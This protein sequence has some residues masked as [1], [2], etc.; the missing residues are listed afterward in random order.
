M[1]ALDASFDITI[2]R[3][4][5]T[6]KGKLEVWTM[7]ELFSFFE[8]PVKTN[9]TIKAYEL[10]SADERAD[11]KD[12]GGYV[13]GDFQNNTRK[14]SNL[15]GRSAVALDMDFAP[16]D[17]ARLLE[18]KLKW[19]Y[20]AHTTHSH[21]IERPRVRVI[22]FLSCPV[23]PKQYEKLALM[24]MEVIGIKYFDKTTTEPARLM[25]WPSVSADG[26]YSCMKDFNLPLYTPSE[27]LDA[28][29]TP[30]DYNHNLG[31]EILSK[32]AEDPTKKAGIIGAFCRLYP[33]EKAIDEL[34]S[35]YYED[36]TIANRYTY[37]LSSTSN[38]AVV[39]D[40]KWLYSHHETDPCNGRLVNSWDLV[41][42]HKFGAL[43]VDFVGEDMKSPSQSAML[44]FAERLPG[45]KG[46]MIK[47]KVEGFGAVDGGEPFAPGDWLDRLKTKK[48]KVLPSFQNVLLI[49]EN[50]DNLSGVVSFNTFSC[51]KV[52]TKSF[53][54][55]PLTDTENG[56]PWG[57]GLDLLIRHYIESRYGVE[58]A[59]QRVC[60]ALDTVAQQNRFN[61][62]T[63]WLSGLEWDGVARVNNL[64]CSYLGAEDS[65]LNKAL[66]RK[67]LCGAVARAYNPGCQFDY[68]PILCGAQ[69]IG[70]SRFIEAL[71]R[72]YSSDNL[73]H[74][75]GN[76][77]VE[78]VLGKWILE[79]PELQAF[80]KSQIEQIKA[81]ITRST[82]RTRLAYARSVQSYP[83]QCVLIGTT[84]SAEFLLDE[85]GNRRFWPI[86]CNAEKVDVEK[87]KK[88]VGQIW[89]EAVIMYNKGEQL[90]LEEEL[91]PDV[92]RAQKSKMVSDPW[93]GEIEAWLSK[94][95]PS[96]YYEI[97][98]GQV[99]P[100]SESIERAEVCVTDVWQNCLGQDIGRLTK[101]DS[102]RL[103][104]VLSALQGWSKGSITK[105]LG[106]RFGVQ[107]VWVRSC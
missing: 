78:A 52:Q 2:F 4:K 83:R 60:E 70:K 89:A 35:D 75:D 25:F 80:N 34:V 76:Q 21:T 72:G 105:R 28:S 104:R 19:A 20:L 63:A 101:R 11:I 8:D 9:E 17:W 81:F 27:R 88:E 106:K 12:V 103:G 37:I 87:L 55:Y 39:Y 1:T 59:L 40:G 14:G 62:L 93:E 86:D 58:V 90:Y 95:I 3:N 66:A 91:I 49:I 50:D 67:W 32:Q 26:P 5:T 6:I 33:I 84:N 64:F 69:G 13:L 45:V 68:V 82:D 24:F 57:D 56:T 77:A 47:S 85:T 48:G 29:N 18:E 16:K 102:N 44:D 96:N 15:L 10:A 53:E 71:A 46:E 65:P 73:S 79:V 42:L 43:D 36:G 7:G 92:L 100:C 30:E 107:K 41:R 99:I 51:V 61:P 38:G 94:P 74:F 23:T 98:Q 97:D 22:I 54:H 31:K